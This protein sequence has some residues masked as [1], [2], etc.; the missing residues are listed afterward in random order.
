M[1]RTFVRVKRRTPAFWQSY[2]GFTLF[3]TFVIT[4]VAIEYYSDYIRR[5]RKVPDLSKSEDLKMMVLKQRIEA[6]KLLEETEE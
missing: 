5:N 6:R 3:L 2:V 1:I 4:P